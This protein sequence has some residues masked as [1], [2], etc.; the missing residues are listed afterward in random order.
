M[1]VAL[2]PYLENFLCKFL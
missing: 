1:S 2:D